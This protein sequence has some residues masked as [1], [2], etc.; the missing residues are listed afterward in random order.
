VSDRNDRNDG[1]DGDG[2]DPRDPPVWRQILARLSGASAAE[3]L[4]ISLAA[5]VLSILVGAV[6]VL[7]SG[8][9]VSCEQP[10]LVLFGQDVCYDPVNVYV[11]MFLGAI[12]G[13]PLASGWNP[14]NFQLASTLSETTLLVF[15]GLSVAVAFRSGMFNIGTQGQMI[16]GGLASALAALFVVELVPVGIP[17][18]VLVVAAALVAGSVVGGLYG[19]LPGALKAYA[20]ANEVITTIMLNF[21]AIKIAFVLT[22]TVFK[23]P[24]SQAVQTRPVPGFARLNGVLF[25]QGSDFGTVALVIAVAL[26]VGVYYLLW[27]TSGGYD[28]RTA[29]IQPEAASYGGVDPKRTIV[30]SMTLSGALGG[31]AGGMLVLMVNGRFINATQ[32]PALGFDG[33]TVSILAGNHPLGVGFAALLFGVLKSGSTAL[34]FETAVPPELVGVLRGL[35]ILFVAMPEFFRMAARWTGIGERRRRTDVAATDGG[36]PENDVETGGGPDGDA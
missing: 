36:T 11:T 35:I 28:L 17:G 30:H 21:V 22:S 16:A 1:N 10:S 5:L 14:L 4:F 8:W 33:I 2:G 24:T 32:I 23:D 34:Q 6:I 26:A 13:N 31:F 15:T 3:R 27:H 20:D 7:I 25:P 9:A 29:G 12:G 19:A 18:A